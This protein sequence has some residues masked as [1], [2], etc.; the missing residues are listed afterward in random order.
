MAI[1]LLGGGVTDIRGSIGGTTFARNAGG[2]Y[3]RARTKPVNPR[4]TLQEHMRTVLNFCS[5]RWS[6]T[7]NNIQRL[8]W[9]DYVAATVWTNRLGQAIDISGYAAYLRT[10]SLLGM[11]NMAWRDD[12]P[13]AN[14]HAAAC[15]VSFEAHSDTRK[16]WVTAI[17]APWDKDTDND[18]VWT[19]IGTPQEVG[20]DSIPKGFKA[21][22]PIAGSSVA[23]HAFPLDCG[24]I[25]R[26]EEGQRITLKS[27]HMDPDFRVSVHDYQHAIAAP[28][29]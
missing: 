5:K 3:I 27:I 18:I 29:I 17:G 13:T 6:E 22:I 25:A 24:K 14:G 26:C 23:P 8:A 28:S 2:A 1:I 20:S 21:R 12:A 15:E 11:S 16:I 4:S 10:N 19:F 7:L 9:R